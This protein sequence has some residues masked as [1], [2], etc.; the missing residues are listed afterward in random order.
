M[1]LKFLLEGNK[2]NQDVVR[3]LEAQAIRDWEG[4]TGTL[5]TAGM[6]VGV[7][8]GRVRVRQTARGM[9]MRRASEGS[10][11]VGYM[12]QGLRERYPG[13]S[14]TTRGRVLGEDVGDL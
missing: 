11:P 12:G 13:L 5:T 3:G 14:A 8:G 4:R 1:C 2:E 6:E 9:G 7:E 10:A